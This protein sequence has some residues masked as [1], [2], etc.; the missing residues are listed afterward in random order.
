M[1]PF[2]AGYVDTHPHPQHQPI[3]RTSPPVDD[4][5]YIAI[6]DEP[7][8]LGEARKVAPYHAMRS[9]VDRTQEMAQK[10]IAEGLLHGVDEELL[11]C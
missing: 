11:C 3:N 6:A 4:V 7:R 1:S 2:S 9:S 8:R 5:G 10:L